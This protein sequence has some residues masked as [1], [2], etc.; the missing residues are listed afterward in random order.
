MFSLPSYLDSIKTDY[1]I[2][3]M[4]SDIFSPWLVPIVFL[5]SFLDIADFWTDIIVPA[6]Y[7]Y[8]IQLVI[9]ISKMYIGPFAFGA[10]KLMNEMYPNIID[11]SVN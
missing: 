2:E 10:G 5:Y 3:K 9:K 7:H 8:Y 1:R 6:P 11:Q 4:V